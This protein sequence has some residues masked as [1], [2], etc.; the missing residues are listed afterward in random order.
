MSIANRVQ[1]YIQAQHRRWEPVEHAQSMTCLQA[2]HSA[3]VG[4]GLMAKAVLLKDAE[5]FV[6]T[7][8]PADHEVHIGE[9]NQTLG[10]R[11]LRF[12]PEH[13]LGPLFPDCSPGALPPFGA[14]YGVATVWDPALAANADV[15]FEGG[16]HHTLVRMK[17]KDFGALMGAAWPLRRHL[18]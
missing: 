9:V 7:V 8:V 4:P 15:Y 2:A 17:G 13:D 16:D 1:H 3:H 14:L 6:L 5:G 18:T 12:A 10:G 11:N